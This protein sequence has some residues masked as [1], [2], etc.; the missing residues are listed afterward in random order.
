MWFLLV[1]IF[2]H[3]GLFPAISELPVTSMKQFMASFHMQ[4]LCTFFP[5]NPDS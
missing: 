2:V 5:Q 3:I 1:Q 4:Y